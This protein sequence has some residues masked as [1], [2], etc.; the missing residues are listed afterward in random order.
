MCSCT[1]VKSV[2]ILEHSPDRQALV[3]GVSSSFTLQPTRCRHLGAP[4]AFTSPGVSCVA[5]TG[6]L[7]VSVA[8]ALLLMGFHV[9]LQPAR[10]LPLC[11]STPRPC[12]PLPIILTLSLRFATA[13]ACRPHRMQLTQQQQRV[14]V[15][16]ARHRQAVQRLPLFRPAAA[17]KQQ[18][19]VQEPPPQQQLQ[20]HE[21]QPQQ[22]KQHALVAALPAPVQRGLGAVSDALAPARRAVAGAVSKVDPRVRGLILLNAM[23]L[24]MGS[25]WVV[26]KGANDAF[27]P[28][29]T[30][31]LPGNVLACWKVT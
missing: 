25:N 13:L 30:F 29:R 18:V 2:G 9:L 28:V 5:D 8:W 4:D 10:C 21:Q 16:P 11:R 22:Q 20:Q 15:V 17:T 27:D 31:H 19:Q 7:G 23:T 3:S 14:G 1:S 24:L 12:S 26:V 6:S